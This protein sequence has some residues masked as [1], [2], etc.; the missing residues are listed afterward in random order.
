M[1]DIRQSTVVWD[2]FD[3]VEN[4]LSHGGDWDVVDTT[5]APLR[6]TGFNAKGTVSGSSYS[7]WLPLVMDNDDAECWS[8]AFGGNASGNAWG[9]GLFRDVGGTN[10]FDGY[11]ARM[12]IGTG[13]GTCRMYKITN[14]SS[15]VLQ[16]NSANPATGGG[17]LGLIRRNGALVQFYASDDGAA[18]TSWTQYLSVSDSTYTT[19]LRAGL[20]TNGLVCEHSYFGAGPVSDWPQE[21]IR[22]PWRYYG[23]E[24][25]RQNV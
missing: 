8:F 24:I 5:R 17:W 7:V 20:H 4:P 19:G 23:S 14:G 1:A 2:D 22:R 15:T 18:G 3:R 16:T 10:A 25:N 9:H 13:G 12:E 21:F 6:A 11:L